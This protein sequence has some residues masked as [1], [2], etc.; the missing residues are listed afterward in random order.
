MRLRT[1][2]TCALAL[3]VL[4]AAAVSAAPARPVQAVK[5]STCSKLKRAAA[6]TARMRAV[7]ESDRMWMRFTLFERLAPSRTF[8]EVDAAGLGVWHKSDPGVRHFRYRQGVRALSKAAAYRM[9][10]EF[11]WY[12]AAGEL[13]RQVSKRSRRCRQPGRL[14]NLQIRRIVVRQ[15]G[16]YVVRVVNDG[17]AM[18]RVASVQLFVD[19]FDAGTA[20]VPYLRARRGRW[21]GPFDAPVCIGSA[22]AVVD[23]AS[24]VRESAEDDNALTVSCMSL[25]GR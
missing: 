2:T 11:R 5:V 21:V 8:E 9:E 10:V 25:R 7:E 1:V 16:R 19:N 4:C 3:A 15:D 22:Q 13:L 23:P 20:R 24:V 17:R 6:F 12:D 18:A 14:P